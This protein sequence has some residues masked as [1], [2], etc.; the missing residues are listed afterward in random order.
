MKLYIIEVRAKRK[1]AKWGFLVPVSHAALV[2]YATKARAEYEAALAV[3]STRDA[4]VRKV[5][6]VKLALVQDEVSK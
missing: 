3:D 6:V 5:R 2:G 1:G 4:R